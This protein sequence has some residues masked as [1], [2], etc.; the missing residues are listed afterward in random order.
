MLRH[1]ITYNTNGM[2]S[3]NKVDIDIRVSTEKF[4]T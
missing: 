4:V 1:T 3:Q 2:V